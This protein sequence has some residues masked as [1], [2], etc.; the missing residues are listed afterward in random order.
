MITATQMLLSMTGNVRPTRAEVSDVA[1][2]ILD[3]TDA[4]MLSEETAIGR[5]P[6]ESLEMI[7]KIAASA[8]RERKIVRSPADLA[9]YFRAAA[10]SGNAAVKDVV[11]LNAVESADALNARCILTRTQSTVA[12][13]LISRFKP[14]CWI[15]SHGGD[16]KTNN[17]L[18]LSYGVHPVCLDVDTNSHVT[19]EMRLLVEAGM[20][21]KDERV[22]LVEDE[23]AG[24]LQEAFLIK[25]IK[26]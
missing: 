13:C 3:G 16:E 26:A 10:G 23:S 8:E 25:I 12:P 5:Y 15:L 21:E 24:N 6:V 7:T 22:I 19:I 4:V 18:A 17:L 20:V 1:N 9:V 14:D 2:A 11:T